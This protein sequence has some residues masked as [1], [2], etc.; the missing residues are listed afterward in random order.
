MR[1]IVELKPEADQNLLHVDIQFLMPKTIKY[2]LSKSSISE[3][4]INSW[5]NFA[6]FNLKFTPK[7]RI[8]ND[9]LIVGDKNILTIT[10]SSCS[11]EFINYFNEGVLQMKTLLIQNRKFQIINVEVLDNPEIDGE[12]IKLY[13][14]APMLS[15]KVVENQKGAFYYKWNQPDFLAELENELKER[16]KETFKKDIPE[17]G[18]SIKFDQNYLKYHSD[19]SQLVT[20]N[21]RK[22]R[23]VWAP[24]YISGD[25]ELINFAIDTGLGLN[26]D[27]G[28]G[29]MELRAPKN[30]VV[31]DK[32]PR[33]P[34][35]DELPDNFGN[36]VEYQNSLEED[37]DSKK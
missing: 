21:K 8:Y 4:F 5:S 12:Q 24:L 37:K 9:Q 27:I 19:I 26:R 16:Y 15:G 7:P 10:I 3:D 25:K 22:Q 1:I 20:V 6:N 29:M 11:K 13:P 14:M 31:V 32:K 28:Y 35:I 34:R 18:I 33:K 17:E 2:I 30:V 36:L 23:A